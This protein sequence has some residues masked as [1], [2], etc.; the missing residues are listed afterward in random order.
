MRYCDFEFYKYEWCG[1]LPEPEFLKLCVNASAKIR[2]R[3]YNSKEFDNEVPK[4][5]K[6]CT[7]ALIDEVSKQDKNSETVGS[8]SVSYASSDNKSTNS[9][10]NRIINEYLSDLY[11][12]NG[13][14][15]L[16]RGC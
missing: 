5:V 8:W 12:K 14:P 16:Y 3:L 2:A 7:C 9:K 15:V 10:Y 11:D 4:Q 6:Y 1:S 13:T